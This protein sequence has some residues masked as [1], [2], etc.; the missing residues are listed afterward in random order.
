MDSLDNSP[1]GLALLSQPSPTKSA[2]FSV[3]YEVTQAQPLPHSSCTTWH[4][5]GGTC[6]GIFCS[7][8]QSRSPR[9]H[10]RACSMAA[11]GPWALERPPHTSLR[12]FIFPSHCASQS[13]GGPGDRAQQELGWGPQP[14]PLLC[15]LLRV[16]LGKSFFLWALF[17]PT[18]N[19]NWNQTGGFPALFLETLWPHLGPGSLLELSLPVPGAYP[20]AR[21]FPSQ[22]GIP[23]PPFL[24]TQIGDSRKTEKGR[25]GPEVSGPS[26]LGR[27]G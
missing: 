11:R 5:S 7:R 16:T 24:S 9:M 18:R 22:D 4:P 13:R 14:A 23:A 6:S 25:S 3:L 20:W 12:A 8:T 27:S 15:R 26:T 10:T 2:A 19:R 17:L 1:R 21:A